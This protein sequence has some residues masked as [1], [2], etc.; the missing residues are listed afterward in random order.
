MQCEDG[1]HMPV[2]SIDLSNNSMK[3]P[4]PASLA[5]LFFLRQLQLASNGLSGTIAPALLSMP[6]LTILNCGNNQLEGSVPPVSAPDPLP[7]G[8]DTLPIT[9]AFRQIGARQGRH[10][11]C[12]GAR[13]CPAASA[14]GGQSA[15][16]LLRVQCCMHTHAVVYDHEEA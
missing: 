3:G 9:A 8:V 13:Q 7:G 5:Q 10:C 6:A 4:L 16:R 15:H 11:V 2:T 12:A 14:A 1:P